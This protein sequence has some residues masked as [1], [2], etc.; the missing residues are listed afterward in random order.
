MECHVYLPTQSPFLYTQRMMDK[1]TWLIPFL[2]IRGEP[3][4]VV[5]ALKGRAHGRADGKEE[6]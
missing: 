1:T 4:I 3:Y 2:S 6:T 5:R